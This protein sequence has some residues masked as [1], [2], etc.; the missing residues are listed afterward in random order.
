MPAEVRSFYDPLVPF[1]YWDASFSIA[2]HS[3]NH[4]HHQVCQAFAYRCMEEG[5][6]CFISDWVLNEVAFYFIRTHLEELG[7]ERGLYWLELYR[8]DPSAVDSIVTEI[9]S[10]FDELYGLT[11]WLPSLGDR[12]YHLLSQI[13]LP[14]HQ[15]IQSA[16]SIALAKNAALSDEALELMTRYRLLPT[17]AYHIA[18]ALTHGIRAFATLDPDFLRVDGIIVFTSL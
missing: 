18:V 7:R 8:L 9:R 13:D 16:A 2:L 15:A 17:D 12:F 6:T 1:I 11:I 5:A 14:A 4:S 3:V 10:V